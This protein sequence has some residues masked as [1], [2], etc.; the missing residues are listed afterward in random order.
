MWQRQRI[1][2]DG[3]EDGESGENKG[4]REREKERG[5]RTEKWGKVTG[6]VGGDG[7][8]QLPLDLDGGNLR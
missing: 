8:K 4:S 3:G 7:E 6:R 2:R 5:K 1:E